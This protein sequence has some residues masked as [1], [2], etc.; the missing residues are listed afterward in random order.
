MRSGLKR[1]GCCARRRGA[2]SLPNQRLRQG[3]LPP[4]RKDFGAGGNSL[5]TC[6]NSA[7][8]AAS[9]SCL[10]ATIAAKIT[11]SMAAPSATSLSGMSLPTRKSSRRISPGWTLSNRSSSLMIVLDADIVRVSV[12]PAVGQPPLV[13]DPHTICPFAV[14]LQTPRTDC[15]AGRACR[16]ECRT[17]RAGT[18]NDAIWAGCRAAACGYAHRSRPFRFPCR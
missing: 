6:R 9:M 16:Q 5:R 14:S 8:I 4:C 1:A 18:A 10:L 17:N 12:G 11:G 13:V 15:P 2:G 3:V 7:S